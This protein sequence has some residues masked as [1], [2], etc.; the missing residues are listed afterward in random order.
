MGTAASRRQGLL[1]ALAAAVTVTLWASAFVGIRAA[2]VH[3]TAGP[4]ALGR[5]L[6]GCVA[7]GSLAISRKESLPARRDLPL[8]VLCG[9]LWFALYNVALNAAER[10]I[11]PGTA[12]MIVN[13]GPVLIAVL[14]GLLLGEGF[15]S[16]LFAGCALAIVGVAIIGVATTRAGIP[17]GAGPLLCLA[18]AAAYSTAVVAQKVVLRRVTAL[19]TTFLSCTVGALACLPFAP[20]LAHEIAHAPARSIGWLVYLGLFPT[21]LGF[22]TWAYALGRTDAGRLGATTYAVPALSILLGW[23]VLGQVPPALA[24]LGGAICLVGVAI[25]RLR[26]RASERGLREHAAVDG[27]LGAGDE[28]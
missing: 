18:A 2:G 17:F 16:P 12:A 11:D 19:Q 22:T 8:I 25:S 21:A 14:A 26:G 5:L 7:L 28:A 24:F 23:L 9:L 13:V 3:F 20:A 15:P 10:R 27:Q 1:A 6:V 4:L